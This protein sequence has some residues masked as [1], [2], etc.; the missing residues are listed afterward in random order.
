MR[1]P[2]PSKNGCGAHGGKVYPGANVD[3]GS[4]QHVEPDVVFLRS[5]YPGG[6]DDLSVLGPP[7]LV[8]EV[9]SPSNKH[10]DLVTKRDWYERHGVPEYWAADLDTDEIVVFR[11]RRIDGYGEPERCG[12]GQPF[13]SPRLP[14]TEFSVDDLLPV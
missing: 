1:L 3:L 8:V 9:L 6:H 10:Y 13:T 11:L 4:G 7:D 5:D 2:L 14:G 12:R